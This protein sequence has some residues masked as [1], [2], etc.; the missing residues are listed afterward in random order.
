M[1]ATPNAPAAAAPA[2]IMI[3]VGWLAAP[4][5]AAA[6]LVLFGLGGPLDFAETLLVVPPFEPVPLGFAAPLGAVPVG[7]AAPE[8]IVRLLVVMVGVTMF[9][10]TVT[11]PLLRPVT[12]ERKFW[13]SLTAFVT[14]DR[15]VETR[16]WASL[17]AFV[18]T[19]RSV[20]TRLWASLTAFVNTDPAGDTALEIWAGR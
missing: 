4:P 2:T 19:D 17:T 1:A 13:A 5:V 14:T 12:V 20:E 16:L 11:V 15:S 7:L 18:T 9:V 8:T 10:G 3:L 6:V